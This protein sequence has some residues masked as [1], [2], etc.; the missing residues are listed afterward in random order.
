MAPGYNWGALSVAIRI[1]PMSFEY[2]EKSPFRDVF[3][4]LSKSEQS[5]KALYIKAEF[6]FSRVFAGEPALLEPL[7][8]YAYTVHRRENNLY[9]HGTDRCHLSF[10]TNLIMVHIDAITGSKFDYFHSSFF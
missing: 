4:H 3:P 2:D 10:V 1:I 6:N 8:L 9:H 7:K 5:D